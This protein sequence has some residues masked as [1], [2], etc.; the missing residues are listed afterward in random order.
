MNDDVTLLV[1]NVAYGG[2][3]SVR[4]TVGIER[5]AR[6]F[7]LDVTSQWPGSDIAKRIRPGQSCQIFIGADK[8][9][10]GYVQATP[11]RYDGAGKTVGIVGR[12]KTADLVDC[13]PLNMRPE[14]GWSD[15]DNGKNGPRPLVKSSIT[16][17]NGRKLEKVA[18]YLAQ[19]FQVIVKTD[20]DTGAVLSNFSLQQGETVFECLDRIMR[21]NHVL[22]SDN[23]NGDMVFIKPGSGGCCTTALELGKNILTCDAPLD[24]KEVFNR[25]TCVGQRS[26]GIDEGPATPLSG[27]ATATDFSIYAESRMRS[28]VVVQSG[29]GGEGTCRDRVEYEKAYRAAK[30]LETTYGVLGW[31]QEDGSLW[32]PNKMVRVRDPELGFDA[33]FLIPEVTYIL[34]KDGQRADIKVGPVN[35]YLHKPSNQVV[36]NWNDVKVN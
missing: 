27:K 7:V 28:L 3:K 9:L 5:L 17:W 35:G 26:V 24:Y 16:Y 12:S 33:D 15:V 19:P 23:E 31:R 10:T 14:G 29:Q 4:L 6:D 21:I 20:V 36:Q 34:D 22:A 32:L 2:W 1:D 11:I 8:M 30:A 18:T 13:S 25:Y